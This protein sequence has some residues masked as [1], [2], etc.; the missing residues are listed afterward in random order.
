MAGNRV[1]GVTH[2]WRYI[3]AKGGHWLRRTLYFYFLNMCVYSIEDFV[4]GRSHTVKKV[5]KQ[6][7]RQVCVGLLF[8]LTMAKICYA[9][10]FSGN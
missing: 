10:F 7:T 3:V 2:G 8:I 4:F 9:V 6:N 1:G 5:I